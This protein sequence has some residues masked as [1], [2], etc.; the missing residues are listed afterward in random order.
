MN[1]RYFTFESLA[2][3]TVALAA[4]FLGI[5]SKFCPET[6]TETRTDTV[7]KYETIEPSEITTTPENTILYDT[8]YRDTGTVRTQ[9]FTHTIHDTIPYQLQYKGFVSTD[10]LIFDSLRVALKEY[11]NCEGISER[12]SLLFGKQKER[13][14]TNTIT[15]TI[16][17]R[18]PLF[19]LNGGIQAGFSGKWN[20]ADIGPVLQLQIGRKFQAGYSYMLNS[21]SNNI[22]LTTK[23]K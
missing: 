6:K 2:F 20:V 13:V 14:I 15:N 5:Y 19:Q 7:T 3:I 17:T 21:K 8:V 22:I 4:F 16:E 9:T 18:P 11:G 23:I 10:T 1:K 12:E